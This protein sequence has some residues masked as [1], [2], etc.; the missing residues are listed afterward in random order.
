MHEKDFSGLA[1]LAFHQCNGLSI[2]ERRFLSKVCEDFILHLAVEILSFLLSMLFFTAGFGSKGVVGSA[3]VV[4]V[5]VALVWSQRPPCCC[6]STSL[7]TPVAVVCTLVCTFG[8]SS[9][10]RKSFEPWV[11]GRGEDHCV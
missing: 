1:S 5:E 2:L 3:A 10:V 8:T 4:M 9:G 6:S 11:A 7:L